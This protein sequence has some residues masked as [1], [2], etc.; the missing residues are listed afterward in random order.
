MTEEEI[1]IWQMVQKTL[2][3]IVGFVFVYLFGRRR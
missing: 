1:A 3:F 2:P